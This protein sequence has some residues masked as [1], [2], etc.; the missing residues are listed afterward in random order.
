MGSAASSC[1]GAIAST[2]SSPAGRARTPSK[3]ES[4]AT[5]SSAATAATSGNGFAYERVPAAIPA[6]TA[7]SVFA[8]FYAPERSSD[9]SAS[10]SA[11]ALDRDRRRLVACQPL[12]E[13]SAR[14]RPPGVAIDLRDGSPPRLKTA[15]STGR[16][17]PGRPITFTA[18]VDR[19][20]AGERLSYS[21]YFD[22]G[23]SSTGPRT[24][25]RFAKRGSYDVVLG[26]TTPGDDAGAS[27][28]VTVQVGAPWRDR[29]AR[30]AAVTSTGR[31]R[32]T[33]PPPE[34]RRYPGLELVTPASRGHEANRG[35]VAL[36]PAYR[37]EVRPQRGVRG[38]GRLHEARGARGFPAPRWAYW[39]PPD[40]LASAP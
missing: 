35:D 7:S 30:E 36:I 10:R 8:G 27:A 26:V 19:A 33:E 25:H 28:V 34:R 32:T 29:T 21:W 17:R 13:L 31:C 18:I 4:A 23:V 14:G 16:A 6:G 37:E 3:P 39:R 38:P 1:C 11:R 15:A 12:D 20:G 22:D 9:A 40:R 5:S 2:S 24:R